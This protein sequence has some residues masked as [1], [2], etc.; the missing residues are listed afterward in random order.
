[1]H[2]VIEA[3]KELTHV[4]CESEKVRHIEFEWFKSHFELATKHDL[5]EMEKR[6]MAK[7]DDLIAAATVLST[8]S[9][10][11]SVKLDALIVKLD[12]FIAAV[13]S[14]DLSPAGETALAALISAKTTAAA[15]GDKV[16]A[17]VTKLDGVLPTPAPAAP[18]V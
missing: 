9:D 14:G 3:I 1:M 6:I 17:E 5:R 11:L 4:L 10:G 18:P 8:A 12:A 16:D 2:E 13:P 7:V 15:A